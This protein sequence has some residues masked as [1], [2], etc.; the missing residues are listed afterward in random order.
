MTTRCL[1]HGSRVEGRP[2]AGR[3]CGV[4]PIHV[5]SCQ[6]ASHKSARVCRGDC[7]VA[8][9]I[10]VL[11]ARGSWH[12]HRCRRHARLALP[13]CACSC[14]R[15]HTHRH[16]NMPAA[17]RSVAC[18]WAAFAA[19]AVLLS[20]AAES[21]AAPPPREMVVPPTRAVGGSSTGMLAAA[22][23]SVCLIGHGIPPLW[24]STTAACELG[25]Y[26]PHTNSSDP[27]TFPQICPPTAACQS[28]RC[29][30]LAPVVACECARNTPC[31]VVDLQHVWQVLRR[32]GDV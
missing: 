29:E 8:L 3:C 18:V 7:D 6:D 19:L 11:H 25:Y 23:A 26:C 32:A 15:T 13:L 2:C 17:V 4:S 30:V 22:G 5:I 28:K 27:A 12:V 31:G 16:R 10:Q 21:A 14:A 24:K 20:R 9:S 1:W